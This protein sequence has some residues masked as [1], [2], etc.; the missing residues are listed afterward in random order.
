V[1]RFLTNTGVLVALAA[2]AALSGPSA[3]DAA[4]FS[5]TPVN[6]ATLVEF[7]VALPLRNEAELDQLIALQGDE[8]SP[9]YHHFLTPE[10]FAAR[11]GPS[12]AA[13]AL[14]ASGLRARGFAVGDFE[15]QSFVV[16]GTAAQVQST[17]G[18]RIGMLTNDGAPRLAARTPLQL[19][20]ELR[21]VN[22]TVIRLDALP[23]PRPDIRVAPFNRYATDGPYWFTD[24]KQAYHDASYTVAKG[25][26]T[27]IAT[28]GDSDFSSADATAYFKFE[29]LASGSG[30]LG[31]A[32]SISH[33]LLTGYTPFNPNNDTAFEANLD[34]QQ[35]A[36]AAP[37]ASVTGVSV[38]A[39][40]FYGAYQ[41]LV[42]SNKYDI[43]STSYGGCE[44][45]YTAAYNGGTS[46]TSILKSYNTVFKQ[47]NA[48]GITFV[49]SSGD[50]S[51]LAC[52]QV[53]YFGAPTSTK[54]K[55]VAGVN[56]WADDPNVTAVGGTNLITTHSSTT[57]ASNYTSESEYADTI[58]NDDPYGTGNVVTN[59]L[60]GSGGGVSVV[61]TK[62]SYQTAFTKV[63]GRSVPDVAMDMAGCLSSS[64]KCGTG[65]SPATGAIIVALGVASCGCFYEAGGTSAS[66]PEF[67]GLLAVKVAAGKS[68]LG[69]ANT[70][71]YK[72]A[73]SN[74]TGKYF[75]Q[76]IPGKNGV[77]TVSK[78]TL[79]YNPIT[80]VG[81]PI[82]TNFLKL[83]TVAAAGNPRTASNP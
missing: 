31:P 5:A 13:F 69:N 81:T 20:A 1:K 51:G 47:G 45:E 79:G 82:D 55:D 61:W 80:G 21:A 29:G 36:G 25:S 12:P 4:T 60:W 38:A 62:P 33:L 17:F 9:Y 68:R 24:L 76:G 75:H 49:F 54:Y 16:R 50:S 83:P 10:Q 78:G 67:A 72:L 15:S 52:P 44:L 71:I 65:N 46:F 19:P 42:K 37:G 40:N 6:L 7:T 35:A 3:A 8:T 63:A 64:W 23:L 77:V 43:V 26:G 18:A 58:G 22:A 53:G 30:Y 34:V 41:Y 48:Q 27:H 70:Y 2:A 66:A 11:Y 59:A 74:A 32:P 73:A 14:A 28:L 56:F 57:L 39:D